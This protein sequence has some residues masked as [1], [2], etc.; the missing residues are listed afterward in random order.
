LLPCKQQTYHRGKTSIHIVQSLVKG[1]SLNLHLENHQYQNLCLFQTSFHYTF[2]PPKTLFACPMLNGDLSRLHT[3][4]SNVDVQCAFYN[5]ATCKIQA[6]INQSL[7]DG[8]DKFCNRFQ[9]GA[10]ESII[11]VKSLQAC[12]NHWTLSVLTC[13]VSRHCGKTP[14]QASITTNDDHW[15]INLN[16]ELSLL[17]FWYA[18]FFYK[19]LIS[20]INAPKFHLNVCQVCFYVHYVVT[21]ESWS[22]FLNSIWIF[23]VCFCVKWMPNLES[24][25]CKFHHWSPLWPIIVDCCCRLAHQL[26]TSTCA[27]ITNVNLCINY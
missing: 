6:T 15:P 24:H 26:L 17:L 1:R 19:K 9:C 23:V 22:M 25:L 3:P 11:D 12:M 4:Y 8:S 13:K 27:L 20:K 5:V 7:G 21:I 10:C 2:P 16:I 14:T 18:S